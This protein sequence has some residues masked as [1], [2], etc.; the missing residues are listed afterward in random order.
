[1]ERTL[2]SLFDFQKFEG[3]SDLQKV[4]DSTHSRY[5]VRELSLDEMEGVAA[6][7]IPEINNQKTGKDADDKH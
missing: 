7:G 3:N 1:M 6:A 2:K 5:A 4:I